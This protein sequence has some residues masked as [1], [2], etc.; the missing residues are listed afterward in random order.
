MPS[1]THAALIEQPDLLCLRVSKF[2]EERV[3][4]GAPE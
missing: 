4:R 2:L 3:F 1:A